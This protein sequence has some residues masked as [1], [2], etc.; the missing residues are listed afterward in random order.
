[1][2][3]I[4]F[5]RKDVLKQKLHCFIEL[6]KY[7]KLKSFL[8]EVVQISAV[9]WHDN[10]SGSS[11]VVGPSPPHPKVKGLSPADGA[12]R[13]MVRKILWHED[14][15]KQK[16]HHFIEPEKYGKLKSFLTEW[17]KFQQFYGMTTPGA[18][19]QW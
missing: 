5:W 4:F 18:L 15:L 6:E 10:A 13:K 14:V 16:L 1:M 9:L 19:A 7:G 8:T 2:M 11:A 17:H 12:R 3:K